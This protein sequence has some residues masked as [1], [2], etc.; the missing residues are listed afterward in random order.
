M[1]RNFVPWR[2][3]N[4]TVGLYDRVHGKLY[5]DANGGTFGWG[6]VAGT[7]VSGMA[8]YAT[9]AEVQTMIADALAGI[10]NVSGVAM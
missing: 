6:A 9:E 2:T 7:T 1:V 8:Q 3:L 4:G 10:T 5:T